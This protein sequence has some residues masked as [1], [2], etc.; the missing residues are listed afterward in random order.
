MS[1][2]SRAGKVRP[3]ARYLLHHRH[4]PRECG[5]VFAAFKGHESPLRR[6]ATL[7]SCRSGGHAIWWTVDAASERDALRQLPFYVAQRTTVAEVDDVEI[8]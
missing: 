3:M 7:A 8:P 1:A 4:H 2:P 5:V 6:R